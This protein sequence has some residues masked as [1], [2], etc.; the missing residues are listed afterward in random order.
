M[1]QRV[2]ERASQVIRLRIMHI[3]EEHGAVFERVVALF[4]EID[5]VNASP[6][7]LA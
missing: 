7:L 1:C 2:D 5:D 3:G 4:R 6:R